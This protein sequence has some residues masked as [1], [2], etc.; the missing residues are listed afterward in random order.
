MMLPSAF[1]T[2]PRLRSGPLY[3]LGAVT[4]ALLVGPAPASAQ[5]GG[6]GGP[7]VPNAFVVGARG[8]YDFKSDAPLLGLF[9]RTSV[10]SRVALQGTADLTFLDGLTERQAGVDLLVRLGS[11]GLFVGGGPVWRSSIFPD[12]TGFIQLGTERETKLGYS[13]VGV[14]GGLPG[15]GRF[16]TGVEFRF[17]VVDELKAQLLTLQFGLPLASW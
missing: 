16:L 8:G 6:S 3:L 15:R 9:A 5:F 10:V 2:L 13:L 12:E 1:L 4:L 11:Q 7:R 14:L 17:T